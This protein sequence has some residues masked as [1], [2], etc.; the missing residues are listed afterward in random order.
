VRGVAEG[1]PECGGSATDPSRKSDLVTEM[2][3][4]SSFLPSSSDVAVT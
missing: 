3:G 2:P 4:T 1:S